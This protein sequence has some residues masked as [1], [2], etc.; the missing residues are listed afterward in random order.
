[1]SMTCASTAV[2]PIWK[3][4]SARTA[5]QSIVSRTDKKRFDYFDYSLNP[6]DDLF[7]FSST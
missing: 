7:T 5:S 1:M 6:D 4:T 2:I 3:A